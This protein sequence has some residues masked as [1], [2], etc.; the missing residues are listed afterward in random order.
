MSCETAADVT[1]PASSSKFGAVEA[2]PVVDRGSASVWDRWS[3]L[4][5]AGAALFF[6]LTTATSWLRWANFE[7]RTFDLAYYVQGIWQL[8]HGRFQ[9][10]VEPVPLL[11]NHVE[12]IVF[13][14]A[15][16]FAAIQHPMVF[17]VVQNAALALMAPIGY[18]FARH[19]FE[20]KTAALLAIALLITPAAGYV[21]LHEFHPEALTAPFLLSMVL[22][23]LERR[24]WLHWIGFLGVLACKENM[25]LLLSAYCIVFLFVEWRKARSAAGAGLQPAS[26][27]QDA[28]ATSHAARWYGLPLVVAIGWFV[29]CVAVITPALNSGGIDY[30]ALYD[31]L[32]KNG[33]DIIRNFFVKP[34]LAL[35]ALGHSLGGGNLVWALLVPFLL[36]PLLRPRWLLVAAPVLLQHLLSWRSSEWNVYFHYGAPLLPLFWV[37]TVEALNWLKSCLTVSPS[38]IEFASYAVIIACLIG[39][40]WIGPA[41]IV[42]SELL[43][44][45][46]RRADRQRKQAFLDKIPADARVVAPLPYLSHLATREKLYSLH[47]ILKGLKTLSHERYVPPDPN[48]I[49]FVL[50]DFNDTATFDVGAGF[51][52]PVMQGADGSILPSSDQLLGTFLMQGRYWAEARDEIAFLHGNEEVGLDI[53][54]D[55]ARPPVPIFRLSDGSELL[56]ITKSEASFESGWIRYDLVWK[57]PQ[58]REV[59]PWMYLRLLRDGKIA[60]TFTKGMC[61]PKLGVTLPFEIWTLTNTHGLPAGEYEAEAVF[62]DNAKR[63]W[64]EA[65]GAGDQKTTLLAPPV[66]LGKL[67]L[68]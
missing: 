50:I 16:I 40:F 37:A 3:V 39:Q 57:L 51:Y 53:E 27:G 12:P 24:L 56:K 52:H 7:Y 35:G 34:Q 23:R 26:H 45:T 63:A 38:R 18:R 15:P 42:E 31:R 59:F 49:D 65:E 41:A 29:L 33:P 22:A 64:S 1:S 30:G 54:I 58:S 14:F 28:H 11:G 62:V 8:I 2:T 6:L 10:T 13:L 20:P 9:L 4:V 67:T 19:Y 46:A 61:I 36:L 32:G 21:A 25:A 68:P 44:Q 43:D 55:P 66:K 48:Q 17:V 60:A 47:Y 5:W